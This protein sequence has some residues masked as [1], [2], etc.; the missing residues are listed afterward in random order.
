M[1][2]GELNTL[3]HAAARAENRDP[4]PRVV[5]VVVERVPKSAALGLFK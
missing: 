1:L 5:I 2:S 3:E 4:S